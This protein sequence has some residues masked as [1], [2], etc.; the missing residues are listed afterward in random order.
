MIYDGCSVADVMTLRW[1]TYASYLG[2]NS[3]DSSATTIYAEDQVRYPG[4]KQSKVEAK[5]PT[6]D[7]RGR[8]VCKTF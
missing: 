4:G 5:S 8:S 3:K 6:R 2:R 7:H 1:L